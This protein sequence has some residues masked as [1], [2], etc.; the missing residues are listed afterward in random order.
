MGVFHGYSEM[1]IWTLIGLKYPEFGSIQMII[2]TIKLDYKA[3]GDTQ[4]EKKLLWL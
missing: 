3:K 4:N 1:K 2:E